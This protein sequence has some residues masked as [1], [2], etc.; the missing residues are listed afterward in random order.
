MLLAESLA[1]VGRVGPFEYEEPKLQLGS[2]ALEVGGIDML[3]SVESSD[4]FG[5][6]EAADRI[7][8]DLLF[9]RGHL[10]RLPYRDVLECPSRI[11]RPSRRVG[12]L[13]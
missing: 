10:K 4:E 3:R 7:D 6:L 5:L 1:P 13:A 12:E 11:E 2:A 8:G 9:D